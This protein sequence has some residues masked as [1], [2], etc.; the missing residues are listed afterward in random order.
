MYKTGLSCAKRERSGFISGSIARRIVSEPQADTKYERSVVLR[1]FP[2]VAVVIAVASTPAHPK[3]EEFDWDQ[4]KVSLKPVKIGSDGNGEF[5]LLEALQRI[6]AD[7][8]NPLDLTS[9]KEGPRK[10][11]EL[12]GM[13]F[14]EAI[15]V[16]EASFELRAAD[17]R[18]CWIP[19]LKGIE[20]HD[21]DAKVV[22]AIVRGLF[23]FTVLERPDG[24]GYC[25]IEAEP[26]ARHF[27]LSRVGWKSFDANGKKP[28][29]VSSGGVHDRRHN[30][31]ITHAPPALQPAVRTEFEA[32]LRYHYDWRWKDLGRL[33]KY[34]GWDF[35]KEG[36][37]KMRAKSSGSGFSN[38]ERNLKIAVASRPKGLLMG[39]DVTL[40][41]PKTKKVVDRAEREPFSRDIFFNGMPMDVDYERLRLKA[42]IPHKKKSIKV[43]LNIPLIRTER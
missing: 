5:S 40:S 33:R 14:W 9:I 3:P 15:E 43:K 41:Y 17:M 32:E 28:I 7:T 2:L 35:H 38:G 24:Q 6:G 26:R 12:K 8:G 18:R 23:R 19:T 20:G 4:R 30:L 25:M 21:P 29:S 22:G 36:A 42:R 39:T 10:K 37:I 34:M 27:S 11:L 1:I 16:L 31:I 13:T